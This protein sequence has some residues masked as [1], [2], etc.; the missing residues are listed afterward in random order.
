MFMFDD[1][2]LFSLVLVLLLNAINII[3]FLKIVRL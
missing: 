3:D 1:L 2:T